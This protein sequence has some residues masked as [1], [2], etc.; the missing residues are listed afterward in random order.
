M[1]PETANLPRQLYTSAAVRELD[2]LIIDEHGVPG[3]VLMRRAAQACVAECQRRFGAASYTVFCGSGN[4]AGD[5]YLIA[6]LL[7]QRGTLVQVVAV[8]DTAKLGPD[9]KQALGFCQEAGVE[10]EP[11]T[12]AC[13]VTGEVIVD[14]MLG[15]GA[16]G[17]PRGAFAAA[18]DLVNSLARPVLAVDV[19]SGLDADR[20]V[21][22]A[23]VVR[24]NVTVTF[25]GLKQG[26]LTADGAE[27]A[28]ALRFAD[29]GAPAAVYERVPA[30]AHRM[31]FGDW[32]TRLGPRHRNAHKGTH[33]HLLVVGGNHGMAGAVLMA[34]EAG[35]RAGAGL[36]S[37]ATRAEH[38]A[39]ILSRRPELMVRGVADDADLGAVLSR[40]TAVVI[41]PGLGTDDWSRWLLRAVLASDLPLVIDADGL[42]LLAETGAAGENV[43]RA[44]FANCIF[45]PHPGE[46]AR[47]FGG[48]V[49][50]RRFEV[51]TSLCQTWGAVVVLKGAGTIVASE[52]K[53]APDNVPGETL[54]GAEPQGT[55]AN[56]INLAVCPYGNPGMAT[57]GMGDTLTGVIGAF[58]A[59]G[60]GAAEAA[61][62]GVIVH[63]LAGD[64]AA[65]IGERGLVATDL[66]PHIRLLANAV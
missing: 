18:I 43:L 4:N 54:M 63:A 49:Q 44:S 37:V 24:A 19:P 66:L 61:E 40:A 27:Y 6:G 51:A 16:V 60:L 34:A 48:A 53:G 46:A 32:G 22:D 12:D 33:G 25:I 29:L 57:G 8:G 28:G 42:S 23:G 50:S 10:P 56:S 45:T 3:L 55:Q 26:L 58:L 7:A 64:A 35:L 59:Q 52:V 14:A 5:G 31:E 38:A 11:W 39:P 21:G 20:G 36:V 30:S 41:G 17:G 15:I 9:A 1:N 65:G 47:L 62:L 13:E 2:R